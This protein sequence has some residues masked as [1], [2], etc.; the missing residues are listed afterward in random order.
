MLATILKSEQAIKA[1]VLIVNAFV[2]MRHFII[3]NK[4]IYKSFY[5]INNK[6]S[7]FEIKIKELQESLD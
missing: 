1:N 6:I 4:E 7:N 5:L 3:D 2:K